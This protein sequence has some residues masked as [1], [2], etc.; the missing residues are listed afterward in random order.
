MTVAARARAPS[1]HAGHAAGVCL[2]RPLAWPDRRC[3]QGGGA[4]ARS[5][6][7]EDRDGGRRKG[8]C[9]LAAPVGHSDGHALGRCR[10]GRG[11]GR[12]TGREDDVRRRLRPACVAFV[13]EDNPRGRSTV[14]RAGR[15]PCD[16]VTR[17]SARGC[18]DE[19]WARERMGSRAWLCRLWMH[20][21][22]HARA[23]GVWLA[24][25]HGPRAR[26]AQLSAASPLAVFVA[27]RLLVSSLSL[28][29]L[30]LIDLIPDHPY[31]HLSLLRPLSHPTCSTH[32]TL[33]FDVATA[34]RPIKPTPLSLPPLHP[35]HIPP[36][37]PFSA[38]NPPSPPSLQ[39][40]RHT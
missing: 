37:P 26:V 9:I 2:R 10:S 16:W 34:R 24:S 25:A 36:L 8:G 20:R 33:S 19:Q 32:C 6:R 11:L 21:G 38:S 7:K 12:M 40:S 17:G 23:L 18:D 15:S 4:P 1:R 27:N 5:L 35:P 14:R 22:E 3:G 31:A 30:P 39:P 13:L 28:G 29:L